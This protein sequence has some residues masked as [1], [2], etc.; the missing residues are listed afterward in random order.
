MLAITDFSLLRMTHPGPGEW[1]A[2]AVELHNKSQ[3]AAVLCRAAQLYVMSNGQSSPW[4][5]LRQVPVTFGKVCRCRFGCKAQGL[6]YS[7]IGVESVLLSAT[8]HA[9]QGCVAICDMRW[10]EQAGLDLRRVSTTAADGTLGTACGAPDRACLS[11]VMSRVY[12]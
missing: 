3:V 11:H 7:C 2:A 4:L 5:D 1:E 8:V 9:A 10:A 6:A 12:C